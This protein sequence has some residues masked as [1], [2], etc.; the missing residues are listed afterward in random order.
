MGE[1]RTEQ[2]VEEFDQHNRG[3]Y[4]LQLKKKSTGPAVGKPSPMSLQLY[5][6]ACYDQ[7]RFRRFVASEAFTRSFRIDDQ[8]SEQV[9]SDDLYA[10]DF[11]YRFL[12]QVLFG[13]KTIDEQDG[14]WDQRVAE[15]KEIWELRRQA[16]VAEHEKSQEEAM[17]DAT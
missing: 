9:Q 2:G 12:R 1:Y 7:D 16:E 3:W 17:R 8:T 14:A 11:A 13:E 10:L 5:F 6:M 15:R 4:Q